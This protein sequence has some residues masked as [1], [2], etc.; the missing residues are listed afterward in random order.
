MEFNN[1]PHMELVDPMHVESFLDLVP[2]RL[3]FPLSSPLVFHPSLEP[4]E[5]IF[6][7][8]EIFVSGSHCLD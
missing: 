7:E 5:S 6:V 1:V 4:S 3:I 2:T 8:F